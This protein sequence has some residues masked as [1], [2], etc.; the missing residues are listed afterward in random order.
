MGKLTLRNFR[1]VHGEQMLA[2]I[3]EQAAVPLLAQSGIVSSPTM[4][5]EEQHYFAE[6]IFTAHTTSWDGH[7]WT[8]TCGETAFAANQFACDILT[9]EHWVDLLLASVKEPSRLGPTERRELYRA[10]IAQA[11]REYFGP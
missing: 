4:K 1:T 5:P 6:D 11:S 3:A 7:D 2:K 8:C 9:R 10:A